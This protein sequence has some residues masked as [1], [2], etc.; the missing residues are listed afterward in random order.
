MK[1]RKSQ[2]DSSIAGMD[3]AI[4]SYMDHVVRKLAPMREADEIKRQAK[5]RQV[6][7]VNILADDI[8]S[9]K[10]LIKGMDDSKILRVFYQDLIVTYKITYKT[11]DGQMRVHKEK[12]YIRN[13]IINYQDSPHSHEKEK[14][15]QDQH[16][17]KVLPAIMPAPAPP[18]QDKHP[19]E[20]RKGLIKRF[21]QSVGAFVRRMTACV[22]RTS[23]ADHD[24]DSA[25]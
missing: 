4:E 10:V 20:A 12:R 5:R 14:E 15:D 22:R 21:R 18:E 24:A 9:S 1:T 23:A 17:D 3:K 16:T 19:E 11:D 25:D 13:M 7:M 6:R 8:V 2:F